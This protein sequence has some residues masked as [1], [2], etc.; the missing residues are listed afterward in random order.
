MMIRRF[1]TSDPEN[2]LRSGGRGIG[3][4]RTLEEPPESATEAIRGVVDRPQAIESRLGWTHTDAKAFKRCVTRGVN[5][6]AGILKSAAGLFDPFR[7]SG[8]A[9]LGGIEYPALGGLQKE[10]PPTCWSRVGG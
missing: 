5:K 4:A 6:G 9:L 10:S 2:R 3:S 7:G 8:G 1:A